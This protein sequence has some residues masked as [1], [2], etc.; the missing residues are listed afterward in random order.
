MSKKILDAER[1]ALVVRFDRGD[2]SRLAFADDVRQVVGEQRRRAMIHSRRPKIALITPGARMEFTRL[3]HQF[4][5]GSVIFFLRAEDDVAKPREERSVPIDGRFFEIER[6]RDLMNR[7]F[8]LGRE[9]PGAGFGD[10]VQA[11]AVA[12]VGGSIDLRFSIDRFSIVVFCFLIMIFRF[13]NIGE[14][15]DRISGRGFERFREFDVDRERATAREI[16]FGSDLAGEPG[17]ESAIWA[18]HQNG[19]F[20]MFSHGDGDRIGVDRGGFG[21]LS[22]REF[23]VEA[24]SEGDVGRI[25]GGPG[26]SVRVGRAYDERNVAA[27]RGFG[28]DQSDDDQKNK[29]GRLAVV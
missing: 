27:E 1:N 15:C 8:R 10:S 11:R 25:F 14:Y 18:D 9:A 4:I 17:S 3:R 5:S 16:L 2:S 24:G 13:D 6:K 28:D 12:I 21:G 20:L 19:S 7:R 26:T 23:E 29:G 22:R